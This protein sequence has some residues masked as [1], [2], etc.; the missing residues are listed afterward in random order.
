M[1]RSD[2]ALKLRRVRA[3]GQVSS[4]VLVAGGVP[5]RLAVTP[6]DSRGLEPPTRDRDAFR[7]L[8]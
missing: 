7:K 2:G 4:I 6:G 8:H 5:L 3:L 1:S